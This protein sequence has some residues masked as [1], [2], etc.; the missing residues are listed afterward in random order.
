MALT[1]GIPPGPLLD[2]LKDP[3]DVFT[4]HY[5]DAPSEQEQ[6]TYKNSLAA[7]EQDPSLLPLIT[8]FIAKNQIKYYNDHKELCGC[9]TGLGMQC[10]MGPG[11]WGWRASIL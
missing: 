7:V 8:P 2:L 11:A 6:E 10:I 4:V 1:D 3:V 5:E 9:Y